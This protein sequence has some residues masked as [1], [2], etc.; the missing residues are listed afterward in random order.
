MNPVNRAIQRLGA[1]EA[2]VVKGQQ[3]SLVSD[4]WLRLAA[5]P[6]ESVV[7]TLDFLDHMPLKPLIAYTLRR[8][9]KKLVRQV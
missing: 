4:D 6:V 2:L 8:L 1:Y 7:G 3:P 9:G 5:A